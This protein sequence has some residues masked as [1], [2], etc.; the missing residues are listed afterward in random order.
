MEK[1]IINVAGLLKEWE[2][3]YRE[4]EKAQMAFEKTSKWKR[5]WGQLKEPKHPSFHSRVLMSD[6]INDAVI[7]LRCYDGLFLAVR[8]GNC[9][10][11]IDLY[12]GEKTPLLGSRGM[13]ID[14]PDFI[15]LVNDI[16]DQIHCLAYP[17]TINPYDEEFLINL[18]I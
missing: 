1:V 11:K 13:G 9:G 12:G 14:N 17:E 18:Y 8:Y 5:F 2:N 16:A 15:N 4:Y 6:Y 3:E 10:Y 7:E